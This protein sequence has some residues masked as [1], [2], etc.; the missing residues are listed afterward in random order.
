MLI[1]VALIQKYILFL[2]PP[3]LAIAASLFSLLFAGG[4]GSVVSGKWNSSKHFNSFSTSLIISITIILYLLALP[5]LFD[6]F[7]GYSL[8]TRVLIS[9]AS[10]FPLGFMMGIPFPTILRQVKRE[11]ENDAAWMWC[12]NGAFSVL[13]S[14][15]ALVLAMSFGFNA[16]LMLGALTYLGIF[17]VG[18]KQPKERLET[19]NLRSGSD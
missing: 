14:V 12:I 16:V 3:T 5:V 4:V 15:L 1:E 6:A 18:R 2:G 7:L 8:L 19:K 11:F 9:F 10:I 17:L 13:G